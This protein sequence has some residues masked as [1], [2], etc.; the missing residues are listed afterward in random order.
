MIKEGF[1][2]S[3]IIPAFLI[4]LILVAEKDLH[5]HLKN[6]CSSTFISLI[7]LIIILIMYRHYGIS[8]WLSL[9]ISFVIFLV[10]IFMWKFYCRKPT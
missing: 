2:Y 3:F 6:Q 10:L 8:K 9:L 5:D 7:C 1:S 4:G